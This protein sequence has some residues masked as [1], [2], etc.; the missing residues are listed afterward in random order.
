MSKKEQTILNFLAPR[1]SDVGHLL[2]A[3]EALKGFV[4]DGAVWLAL[5]GRPCRGL[6]AAAALGWTPV[7]GG[8]AEARPTS[9]SLPSA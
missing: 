9:G 2:G 4:E 5:S 7:R 6:R 3:R 8:C 1:G